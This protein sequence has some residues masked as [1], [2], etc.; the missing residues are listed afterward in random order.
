MAAFVIIGGIRHIDLSGLNSGDAVRFDVKQ[1]NGSIRR[2]AVQVTD[3]TEAR[4]A[5]I[6]KEHSDAVIVADARSARLAKQ[7]TD[8]QAV[9]DLVNENDSVE[10]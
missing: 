1:R 5:E 9:M 3:I 4:I 7:A 6:K 2:F 8:D 10:R